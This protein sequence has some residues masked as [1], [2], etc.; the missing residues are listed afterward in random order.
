MKIHFLV[1]IVSIVL[2]SC[3]QQ[4]NPQSPPMSGEDIEK[5]S[6]R[7]LNSIKKTPLDQSE[8]ESDRKI[9][10]KIRQVLV[11]DG[12]LSLEAKKYQNHH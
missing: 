6:V 3:N 9:T 5:Q 10:Q 1:T 4:D 7:D 12:S 8:S 2:V 11:S